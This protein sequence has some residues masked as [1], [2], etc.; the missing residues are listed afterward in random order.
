MPT[1]I[2]KSIK[3]VRMIIFSIFVSY[4]ISI[5]AQTI[6]NTEN[7]MNNNDS[8]LSLGVG[9]SG[10]FQYGNI[11]LAQL[12]TTV[13]IG[14]KV[15][16]HLIRF[17]GGYDYLSEDNIVLSSDFISQLRYNY[18]IENNSLFVFTQAQKVKSL[19]L[20]YRFL[21]GGGYRHNL[22]SSDENYF[23]LS[24]GLFYE[25]EL[26]SRDSLSEVTIENIRFSNNAFFRINLT[27]KA[28]V[29][30]SMYYQLNLKNLQDVRLFIEP[31]VYYKFKNV[32]TYITS[33]LRHHTTPYVDVQNTDSQFLIGF[34]Y[35]LQ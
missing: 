16:Q 32:S 17:I 26:Y 2:V 18:Y 35:Q 27:K 34:E 33:Q 24:T 9:L 4:T 28:F 31:R 13:Q 25:Q 1:K 6:V 19:K 7:M 29:N 3:T 14:R 23:D 11:N 20:N 21:A 30:M 8:T 5:N 22:F 15:N 12:N 10:D